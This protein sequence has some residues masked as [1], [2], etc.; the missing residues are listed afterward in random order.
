MGK[1]AR[2]WLAI[3]WGVVERF[4]LPD[5]VW[6]RSNVVTRLA[7]QPSN[8]L[9][10]AI[11]EGRRERWRVGLRALIGS[12]GVWSTPFVVLNLLPL[13]I[14]PPDPVLGAVLTLLIMVVLVWALYRIFR[15][16]VTATS[17]IGIIHDLV[18]LIGYLDSDPQRWRQRTHMGE[19]KSRLTTLANHVEQSWRIGRTDVRDVNRRLRLEMLTRAVAIRELTFW[20]FS[21]QP[22]TRDDLLATLEDRLYA[23]MDGRWLDFPTATIT[24]RPRLWIAALWRWVVISALLGA[25]VLIQVTWPGLLTTYPILP[26]TVITVIAALMSQ[27]GVSSES[28]SLASKLSDQIASKPAGLSDK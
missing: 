11:I 10:D 6:P 9:I 20:L 13:R 24:P 18:G 12:V 5:K 27:V 3:R 26:V 25:L 7:S 2:T 23:A 1:Q 22:Q 28:V 15:W 8:N 4:R 16:W 21:P 19:L 17:R 14:S